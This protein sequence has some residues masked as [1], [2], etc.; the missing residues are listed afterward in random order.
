MSSKRTGCES[1]KHRRLPAFVLL[2]AAVVFASAATASNVVARTPDERFVIACISP[3]SFDHSGCQAIA[4]QRWDGRAQLTAVLSSF[5]LEA[6]K[7]Y[8]IT[9]QYICAR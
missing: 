6:N 5:W 7:F 1:M 4:N 8:N 2:F 9:A 3:V